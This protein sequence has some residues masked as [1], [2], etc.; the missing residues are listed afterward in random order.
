MVFFSK[1]QIW[2]WISSLF[3]IS[4]SVNYYLLCEFVFD[5]QKDCFYPTTDFKPYQDKQKLKNLKH[6]KKKFEKKNFE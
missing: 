3:R 6:K 4:I 5:N 1:N 2:V